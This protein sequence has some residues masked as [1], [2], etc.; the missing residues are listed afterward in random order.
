MKNSRREKDQ[1]KRSLSKSSKRERKTNISNKKSSRR[2]KISIKIGSRKNL[3]S[4][5]RI[6]RRTETSSKRNSRRKRNSSLRLRRDRKTKASSKRSLSSCSKKKRAR[7]DLQHN[8]SH[9][10]YTMFKCC[11][12]YLHHTQG[13][14]E[15]GQWSKSRTKTS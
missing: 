6:E 10:P 13:E 2:E 7:L 1:S 15:H 14:H 3:S 8:N 4:S 11:V 5:S 9:F 12:P